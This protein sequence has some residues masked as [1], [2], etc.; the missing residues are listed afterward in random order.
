LLGLAGSTLTT[1]INPKG[2]L[3]LQMSLNTAAIFERKFGTHPRHDP[4]HAPRL[5]QKRYLQEL[6]QKLPEE[7]EATSASQL[8]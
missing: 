6:Q 8:R 3:Y 2:N 4:A 1:K 5:L 7:F